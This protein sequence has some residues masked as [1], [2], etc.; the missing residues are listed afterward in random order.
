M[1]GDTTDSRITRLTRDLNP[2]E[3]VPGISE[4]SDGSLLVDFEDV[5]QDTVAKIKSVL[6]LDIWRDVNIQI[7]Q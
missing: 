6:E 4:Q 3:C 7:I 2:L 1:S 5:C